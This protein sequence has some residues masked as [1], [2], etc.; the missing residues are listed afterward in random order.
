M[1]PEPQRL[2]ISDLIFGKLKKSCFGR[3]KCVATV[4]IVKGE[5]L[6]KLT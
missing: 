5:K 3:N 6:G 1:V 2:K 4:F